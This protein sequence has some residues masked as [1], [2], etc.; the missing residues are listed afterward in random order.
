MKR[1][2]LAVLIS[3]LLASSCYA[4]L[5]GASGQ[6]AEVT[7][8]SAYVRTGP[9]QCVGSQ[10]LTV[11]NTAVSLTVPSTADFCNFVVATAGV[12]C[13]ADGTNPTTTV[14]YPFGVGDTG[15]IE[16]NE[17]M[18]ATKFVYLGTTNATLDILYFQYVRD[19]K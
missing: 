19:A 17:L 14:G 7:G 4:A 9:S 15:N 1:F 11:S 8:Y 2:L 5:E 16:G 3:A 13:R 18:D 12:R 6:I 10:Q